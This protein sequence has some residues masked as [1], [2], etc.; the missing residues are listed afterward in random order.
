[1]AKAKE[2]IVLEIDQAELVEE[3]AKKKA[4][5]VLAFVI[6]GENYCVKIK[7]VKEVIRP[8]RIT[9]VPNSPEFVVG[10]MNLRGDIIPLLDIRHFFGLAEKER[11]KDARVVITDATGLLVGI[12][13][14]S[15]TDTLDIEE[16]TIQ[17]PLSTLRKELAGYTRGQ[18]KI[19]KDILIFLDFKSI[20]KSEDII[21]LRKGEVR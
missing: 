14:D 10:V 2:K 19:G 6:G 8:A 12:L 21:R 9:G 4:V 20:F 13:V 15:I 3:K 5:R 18:V 11:T 17:P 7:E 16:E 1:M